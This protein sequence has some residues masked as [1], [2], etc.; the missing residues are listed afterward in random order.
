MGNQ[1]GN[2]KDHNGPK[3]NG[4]RWPRNENIPCWLNKDLKRKNN[5]RRND[6]NAQRALRKILDLGTGFVMAAEISDQ[7]GVLKS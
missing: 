7:V 6:V 2:K 3:Q 1:P 4:Q 5:Q